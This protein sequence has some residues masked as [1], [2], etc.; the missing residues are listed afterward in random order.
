MLIFPYQLMSS[1][2]TNHK[3]VDDESCFLLI[4]C[5]H[6]PLQFVLKLSTT[7][8]HLSTEGDRTLVLE[9]NL[10]HFWTF[11]AKKIHWFFVILISWWIREKWLFI[12]YKE[13]PSF[14]SHASSRCY[15]YH[16]R[17]TTVNPSIAGGKTRYPYRF[18]K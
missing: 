16:H 12:R 9:T 14:K 18:I 8:R 13:Q 17:N 15:H 2:R 7:T 5:S 1:D 6:N 10:S 3:I 11:C 4:G